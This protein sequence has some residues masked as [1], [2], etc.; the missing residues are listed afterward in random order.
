MTNCF[1]NGKNTG[2]I[3]GYLKCLKVMYLVE[4][5]PSFLLGQKFRKEPFLAVAES[6]EVG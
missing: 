2:C 3:K 6:A 1:A 5:V 4:R